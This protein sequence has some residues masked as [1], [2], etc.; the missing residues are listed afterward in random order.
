MKYPVT[1]PDASDASCL[2]ADKPLPER[3]TLPAKPSMST[4]NAPVASFAANPVPVTLTAVPLGP[5]DGEMLIVGAAAANGTISNGRAREI[6]R[7]IVI[8]IAFVA[9]LFKGIFGNTKLSISLFLLILI[10]Q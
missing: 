10:E 9:L 4:V 3:V 7:I 2:P 6:S 8:A 1:L 5:E